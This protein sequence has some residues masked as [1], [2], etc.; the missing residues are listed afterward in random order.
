M[1]CLTMY[2]SPWHGCRVRWIGDGQEL[3]YVRVELFVEGDS[4]GLVGPAWTAL[5]DLLSGDDDDDGAGPAT[6]EGTGMAEWPVVG[7]VF[8]VKADNVAD[9]AQLAIDTAS[10]ALKDASRGLYGMTLIP[11]S[12]APRQHDPM[13]PPLSD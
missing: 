11:A 12:S 1:G 5:T 9:A 8:H 2:S 7:V 4:A 10:K 3:W 13:F 6:D